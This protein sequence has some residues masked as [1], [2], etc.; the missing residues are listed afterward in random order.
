MQDIDLLAILYTKETFHTDISFL[1]ASKNKISL[2]N[3]P[4]IFQ[5]KHFVSV[6]TTIKQ[7]KLVKNQNTVFI[8]YY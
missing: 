7:K 2:Y 1:D 8:Y 4:I 6:T 5:I 3:S